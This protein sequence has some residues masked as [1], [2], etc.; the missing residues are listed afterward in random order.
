M[1]HYHPDIL[2]SGLEAVFCGLNPATSAAA[3]GFNFSN[4]SNRFWPVLFRSG[5][6][7]VQLQPEDERRLLDY[8]YGITVAVERPTSRAEDVSFEEFRR[9][10]PHFEHK[11][12]RYAPRAIGFLGKRAFSAMM[13]MADVAWGR[14]STAIAGAVAWIL[15]NPSGRNRSFTFDGLVEAYSEFRAALQA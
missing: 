7:D 12:R 2:R 5:F 6:T 10:R 14:Q 9:S 4:S 3:A 15:P 13:N 11:M 1:S 8:G